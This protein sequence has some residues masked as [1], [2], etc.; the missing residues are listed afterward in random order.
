MG[1]LVKVILG[2]IALVGVLNL[3]FI[4]HLP[5][6]T[7]NA[8]APTEPSTLA[9]PSGGAPGRQLLRALAAPG[10]A[11]SPMRAGLMEEGHACASFDLEAVCT[12]HVDGSGEAD[13]DGYRV[14]G[15]PCAWCCGHG[16]AG[17]G[18]SL[19]EP[20]DWLLNG[21]G[22]VGEWSSTAGDHCTERPNTAGDAQSKAEHAP[23]QVAT[24]NSST[25]RMPG[26]WREG[27]ACFELTTEDSCVVH[28]DGRDLIDLS[29]LK[30]RGEPCVWCC[31]AGCQGE[32][33]HKCEPRNWLIN[34]ETYIGWGKSSA[35]DVCPG[36][37][38]QESG[39]W[40]ETAALDLEHDLERDGRT[41]LMVPRFWTPPPNLDLDS[42]VHHLNGHPSIF[43]MV[44]SYRDFQCHETITSILER[45]AYPG[46]IIVGAV[47]QFRPGDLPCDLPM[48]GTCEE[49]P[50]QALCIHKSRVKVY[51]MD[52]SLAEGP[53][54]ARHV[55]DR[56][57]RGEAYRIQ[58][59]AHVQFIN[60]WDELLIQQWE[61]AH[62][63]YAIISTYLTDLQ[64]SIDAKGNSLRRT[65][66][67]M[68]NTDYE[69]SQGARY[70]RH[71]A[72]PE[73][74]PTIHGTP[75]LQPFWA[76]GM[77]FSRGHAVVRVPYD[78]C[79]PQVFM[80]EEISMGVRYWTFGYDI[81]APEKSVFF[82]E[83]AVYS[84]RRKRVK[85]FHENGGMEKQAGSLRRLTAIIGMNPKAKAEGNYDMTNIES[86]GIGTARA[87]ELL[88]KLLGVDIEN[89]VRKVDLCPFVISGQM[90][91][92]FTKY[93]RSDRKGID[94][95]Q[96]L[97]FDLQATMGNDGQ[98][99]RR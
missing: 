31:D 24:Y 98:R 62:N 33:T 19:C 10:R 12:G 55:G 2:S 87:P 3:V 49:N 92:S 71:G 68:C 93:I 84:K 74:M 79:A 38:A 30:I 9:R 69:G 18:T 47:E 46:R 20:R 57:Y 23:A 88:Y 81:Y 96:L 52:A 95:D 85:M 29:G 15:E 91:R 73:A 63:E 66:P 80:G 86:Y 41:G 75:M 4:G 43:V 45:A 1:A 14:H 61:T 42:Y 7:S 16:C 13:R 34:Q 83:Y 48:D 51:K 76:A 21:K 97:D 28:V 82:H 58:V 17:P 72:Q 67:I 40:A 99:L 59:D 32:G 5:H 65:R 36:D 70:L 60:N 26:A 77:A 27:M 39:P 50:K 56:M 64:G 90:H 25:S 35:G 6:L 22:Y 53:V 11:E 54:Y 89:G 94:Y 37:F 78:C 8:A 44:G